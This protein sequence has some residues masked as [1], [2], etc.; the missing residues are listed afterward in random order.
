MRCTNDADDSPTAPGLRPPA[1]ET[2]DVVRPQGAQRKARGRR[3]R[4]RTR[5]CATTSACS[6]AFSATPCASRRAPTSSTS[7][8]ASARPRSASTATTKSARGASWRRRST[9]STATRRCRSCAPSAIS[10]I[11]P[12]SPRTST[13][14]AATAPMCG[15][16]SAPRPGSLAHAF[17]R[18]ARGG[19][20]RRARCAPSSISALV[21]PVLTAHPTE[22]RRKS[23]LTRE[24]EIAALIDAR[25]RL[26]G[27]DAELAQQ[28][29][30]A[31]P[32]DPHAVAHQHAA[33]DAAQGDR[34]SRQR[35]LLLRLHVLPRAAAHLRRDRGRARAPGA[36][37]RRQ[38]HRLV[39]A[40]RL[41]DRRRPRRQ[42]VRHRRGAE[43]GDAAA[44]RARA[45]AII[46]RSCTSSAANCR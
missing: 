22:V 34:R 31:A 44:E 28:R 5:R 41:V 39:P 4:K 13:T 6:A 7:S 29:G 16:K 12:T 3:S 35:P 20:R 43:R 23:T 10:R 14:S 36:G 19:D 26:A 11:S 27:D 25:E 18:A 42:P 33:P 2:A 40:R 38:A 15:S 24:L 8:S 46:S 30:A 1:Q 32:R 45:A 37:R 21:S 9:A 17:K